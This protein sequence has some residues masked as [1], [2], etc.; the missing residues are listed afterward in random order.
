MCQVST[1]RSSSDR[2]M[3]RRW[4]ER[5][6]EERTKPLPQN[7]EACENKSDIS[8]NTQQQG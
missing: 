8:V 7:L 5:R 1:S 4:A 2:A 6:L 3:L